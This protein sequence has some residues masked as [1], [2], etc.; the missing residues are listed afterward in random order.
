MNAPSQRTHKHSTHKHT[1]SYN[2][3]FPY[4]VFTISLFTFKRDCIPFVQI[5]LSLQLQRWTAVATK[6]AFLLLCRAHEMPKSS[7][8]SLTG[9]FFFS[10]TFIII[11]LK[12][13]FFLIRSFAFV[14]LI[15]YNFSLRFTAKAIGRQKWNRKQV[16]T[17]KTGSKTKNS[18]LICS[19][20]SDAL[21]YFSWEM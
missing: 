9:H 19:L 20:Q 11:S 14:S 7:G 4:H 16:K 5:P 17:V 8:H 1:P 12:R 15:F 10:A 13:R 6:A 18:I 2:F 3:T 21:P